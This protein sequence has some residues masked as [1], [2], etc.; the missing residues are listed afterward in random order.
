MKLE[1]YQSAIESSN[2]I[3]KTD[4]FGIITFVNDEFCKI[5][6]YTKEE[7][8]G[9]NHN[10]VRHPDVPASTFKQLWQTIL[11][12]KRINQRLKI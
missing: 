7:L 6:G 10:I 9:K 1:Q 4:I 11:Q 12:K 8:V 2:I 3:S 5:S